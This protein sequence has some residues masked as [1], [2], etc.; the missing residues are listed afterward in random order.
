MHLSLCLG[1]VLGLANDL[2][3]LREPRIEEFFDDSH[4]VDA[5]PADHVR[6]ELVGERDRLHGAELLRRLLLLEEL[7]LLLKRDLILMH[8]GL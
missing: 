4:F 6:P 3:R 7:L 8:D 2:P 1:F 5:F